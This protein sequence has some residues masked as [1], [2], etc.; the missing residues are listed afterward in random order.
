M[1]GKVI[2]VAILVIW[3]PLF[4]EKSCSSRRS[5]LVFTGGLCVR[6][7]AMSDREREC[8]HGYMRIVCFFHERMVYGF[9]SDYEGFFLR[10]GELGWFFY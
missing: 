8:V 10:A 2:S 4:L 5:V 3:N 6:V 1:L 7:L 9:M